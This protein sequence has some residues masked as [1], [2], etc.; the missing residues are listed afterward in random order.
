VQI[1]NRVLAAYLVPQREID[2]FLAEVRAGGYEILR[3]PTQRGEALR[4]LQLTLSEL[5]VLTLEVQPGCAVDGRRL[6]DTDLRNLFG[7][8]VVAIR[9]GGEIIANP[10]GDDVL[11][12]GDNLVVMGLSEEVSVAAGLFAPSAS[13]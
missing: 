7:I 8:T 3:T 12:S 6:A 5:E 11:R 13:G 2:A 4:D 1:V 10:G 9:R